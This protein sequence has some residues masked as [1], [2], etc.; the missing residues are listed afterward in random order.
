LSIIFD[1]SNIYSQKEKAAQP[2][3][4]HDFVKLPF[5][6]GL[7]PSPLAPSTPRY[8]QGYTL[9]KGRYV[10]WPG[11]SRWISPGGLVRRLLLH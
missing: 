3:W 4:Q 1:L 2:P 7:T 10:S 11:L 8:F 6:P 9:G 5:L